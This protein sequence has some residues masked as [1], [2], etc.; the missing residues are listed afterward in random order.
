MNDSGKQPGDSEYQHDV[1]CVEGKSLVV[2]V[3]A[4]I[5]PSG[6]QTERRA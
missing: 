2:A 5:H 4:N 1:D 6:Y 3:F